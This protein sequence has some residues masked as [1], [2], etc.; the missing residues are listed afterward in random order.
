MTEPLYRR[1]FDQEFRITCDFK[2]HLKYSTAPGVDWALPRTTP[3]LAARQ[4]LIT[5]SQWGDRGG[6]YIMIRH[7]DGDL[8]LYSH[9][10]T[11]LRVK[12]EH[13]KAGYAIG[14]SGS[15]GHST[16]PHLHFALKRKGKWINPLPEIKE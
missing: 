12:G 6:R 15:T 10:S 14:L 5:Y 13:V 7:P 8:T 3:V 4:G 11:L 16:G 9:L 1:P 2:C